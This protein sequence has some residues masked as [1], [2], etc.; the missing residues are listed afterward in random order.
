MDYTQSKFETPEPD[1]PAAPRA[2]LDHI[3][4]HRR[5]PVANWFHAA[6]R[7]GAQTPD[8]VLLAI[9]NTCLRRQAWGENADAVMVLAALDTDQAAALRY[10]QS[11]IDYERLPYAER[12]RVKAERTFTFLKQTMAG[13]TVTA[14]Q[15]AY[16]RKLGYQGA[17]PED[18]ATASAL[19]DQLRRGEGQP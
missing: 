5:G 13:E 10:A 7:S 3:S 4:A 18:R 9:R 1:G 15:I 8:A 16:L 19:I 17:L 2:W 12:Q 11:V 6:V 14:P